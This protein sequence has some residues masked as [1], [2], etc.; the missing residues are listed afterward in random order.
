M[1]E[2]EKKEKTKEN[3]S[4][5]QID[6]TKDYFEACERILDKDSTL[7][8][9]NV[10]KKIYPQDAKKITYSPQTEAVYYYK[11]KNTKDLAKGRIWDLF[12]DRGAHIE[13]ILIE[14]L[15]AIK[16]IERDYKTITKEEEQLEIM[17]NGELIEAIIDFMKKYGSRTNRYRIDKGEEEKCRIFNFHRANL[18]EEIIFFLTDKHLIINREEVG[19]NVLQKAIKYMNRTVIRW[20][21][22]GLLRLKRLE[23]KQKLFFRKLK[24]YQ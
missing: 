3:A 19:G 4:F 22:E 6:I 13:S 7:L 15:K 21:Y 2:V 12:E 10:K 9:P 1:T 23:D 17:R 16:E 20:Y 11:S 5:E 14:E 8:S 24:N 18:K